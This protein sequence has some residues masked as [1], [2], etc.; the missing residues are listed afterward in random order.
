MARNRRGRRGGGRGLVAVAFVVV[1]AL[2]MAL[3]GLLI[4]SLAG[5]KQN[6]DLKDQVAALSAENDS[7]ASQQ[8]AADAFIGAAG[9]RMLTGVLDTRSVVLIQLPGTES[10]DL[11][12]VA[13]NLT[14]AGATVS[15]TLEVTGAVTDGSKSEYLR[16]I[17]DQVIPVGAEL[18]PTLV[19][20]AARLGD[21]LGL[22]LTDTGPG[23]VSA[24]DRDAAL[25]ALREGGFVRYDGDTVAPASAAVLFTGGETPVED[26]AAG[27]ALADFAAA[28]G[29]HTGA[30]P[31]VLAGR[32]GSQQGGGALS[33]LRANQDQVT[34]I[35]SVDNA[36]TRSGAITV[37]LALAAKQVGA[38]GVG[39][40][41]VAIP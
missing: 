29:P 11:Q 10:A 35:S 22:I 6:D 21:L 33:A 25:A 15:G 36:D 38:F 18:E 34:A 3:G 39:P 40:D 20:P 7:L 13:Q 37:V 41:T 26:G 30:T 16:G 31:S 17:V 1:L 2:G 9:D 28:Y 23:G 32:S 4:P 24:A 5:D 12:A 8:K 19:E 14:T 27:A